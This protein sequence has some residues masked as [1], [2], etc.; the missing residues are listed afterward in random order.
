M[1]VY[2]EFVDTEEGAIAAC[3]KVNRGLNSNDPACCVVVDGPENN[4]AVIDLETAKD[5]LDFGEESPLP[6]L[7]VTD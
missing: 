3:R 2:C 1:M 7:I 4:S 6:C 5:L